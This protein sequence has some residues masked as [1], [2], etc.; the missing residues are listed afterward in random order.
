MKGRKLKRSLF[1][2]PFIIVSLSFTMV[3]VAFNTLS[4]RYLMNITNKAISEEFE[5]FDY[6]YYQRHRGFRYI[7]D[8]SEEEF[9]IPIY[10]IVLGDNYE[11][12]YPYQP[13]DSRRERERTLSIK[14]YMKKHPLL[15]QEKVSFKVYVKKEIYYVKLKKYKGVYEDYIFR[16]APED[17]SKIYYLLVYTNITAL[18]NFIDLLNKILFF[19]MIGSGILSLTAFF[20]M[21][22]KI[23]Y[24]MDRLK[25]YIIGA[26]KRK[27]LSDLN[28]LAYDEFDDLAETVKKMSQMVHRAEESQKQFFQ[29]A[30]HELRTPLMSIQGYAEGIR[31]GVIKD[32]KKALDIII[33]E[34]KRMSALV[35][36]ILLLSKIDKNDEE[37]LY[38]EIDVKELL[39]DCTW[40]I[41]GAADQRGLALEHFFDE[42]WMAVYG[43]E[44]QLKSAI[45]NILSNALRYAKS[46]ISIHCRKEKEEIQIIIFNDGSGISEKDLPNIFERFYKGEGGNTGIGLSVTK[47]I[48]EKHG[49][50]IEAKNIQGASFTIILPE[51]HE[52]R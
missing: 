42:S 37:I 12:L 29:N 26:G 18:Q 22:K 10:N 52:K 40:S 39:F 35:A 46:K 33:R 31:T 5:I 2:L 21:A 9:A 13:W 4:Y 20:G 8:K 34:S 3:F 43:N 41:K 6:F 27:E 47:D 51:Y 16:E 48:I 36:D 11:L 38:E 45:G 19:L 23:N 25:D 28:T 32:Q 1:L 17:E 7:Y 24:S 14:D 15:L 44:E 30:S 50:R 49:G